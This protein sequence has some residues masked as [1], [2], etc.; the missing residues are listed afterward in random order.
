MDRCHRP[1]CRGLGWNGTEIVRCACGTDLRT[2]VR[3]P[4]D[5]AE[6]EANARVLALATGEAVP[7]LPHALSA[8]GPADLVRLVMVT[9][10]FLTGWRKE[11]RIET[12]V[13]SGPDAVAR[14]IAEGLRAVEGWPG[15]LQRFLETAR[16]ASAPAR[17]WAPTT[18]G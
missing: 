11:R 8:V 4:V 3:S 2:L 9:G 14:V 16:A 12:L 15:P 17:H 10:M 13:A 1:R 18:A 5:A 6:T 7:W